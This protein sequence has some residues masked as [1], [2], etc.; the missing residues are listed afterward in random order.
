MDNF[1]YNNSIYK[2][3]KNDN[4]NDHNLKIDQKERCAL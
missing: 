2:F 1:L 4:Y 3:N